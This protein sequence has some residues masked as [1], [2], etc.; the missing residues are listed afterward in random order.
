[1][2]EPWLSARAFWLLAFA[3]VMVFWMLG[4][5]NRLQQMRRA[6]ADAWAH[7]DAA[8]QRRAQALPELLALVTEALP[9]EVLTL[10][11]IQRSQADVDAWARQ[12]QINPVRA[13]GAQD[14]L[15]QLARL[16]AGLARLTA[17][18][19]LNPSVRQLDRVMPL[20][21]ELKEADQRLSFAR[22][23]FNDAATVYNV[24]LEE[25]PTRLLV[26]RFGMGVSGTL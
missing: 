3:C 8:L 23:L 13:S 1:M 6:I 16:D 15:H 5:Y 24:A 26:R 14:L 9:T 12:M 20:L 4:A 7:C 2:D 19:E 18:C 17:L 21:Q 22:Q 11:S 10:E 25:F